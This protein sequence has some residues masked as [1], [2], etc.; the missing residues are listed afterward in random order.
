MVGA[1]ADLSEATA[2]V[3]LTAGDTKVAFVNFCSIL[4]D[5]YEATSTRAG[6]SPLH[7]ST[8]YEPLENIYEQPGTPPRTVTVVD[9]RDLKRALDT[10]RRAKQDSDIVVACF[11][12]GV[13]FTHDLATYQPDVGYAAIDAGA[14]I[15]LGTHPH[16]LQAIDVY[17]GKFI[18]YSLGNF[19]FEQEAKVAREGVSKYLS[20]YG[21]PTDAELP[22]H[23]H[24]YHCR[25]T[26]IA[27]FTIKEGSVDQLVLVPCFF[28]AD[29]QPEP[30]MA[31]TAL[32][33][34]VVGLIERLSAEIG[35]SVER[36]GDELVVL[37]EKVLAIDAR[38]WVRDRVLS[39]PWL[40][41]IAVELSG[42]Q[43]NGSE[44]GSAVPGVGQ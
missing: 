29:A 10:I 6:I 13:H 15:V 30:L 39:Y 11:H 40:Q 9:N 17:K 24:P 38:D 22:Q 43:A 23:P 21:L 27:K 8:F 26:V 18:L 14:D 31:G 44:V 35:T 34:N 20:F 33:E 12:W 32:F 16:C 4:R 37:P 25:K 36:R 7:V 2:P 28:N 3:T 5:G 42:S 1:G 41:K 19:A